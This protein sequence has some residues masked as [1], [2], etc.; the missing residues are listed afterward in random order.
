MQNKFGAD[1]S[2]IDRFPEGFS[3]LLGLGPLVYLLLAGR[4]VACCLLLVPLFFLARMLATYGGFLSGMV[5]TNVY[6]LC[7]CFPDQTH[8]LPALFPNDLVPR[9]Q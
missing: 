1:A 2:K 5:S 9:S 8:T 3:I 4:L 6:Q 7:D